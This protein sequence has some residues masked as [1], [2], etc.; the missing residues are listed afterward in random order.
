MLVRKAWSESEDQRLRDAV[1][2][3]GGHDWPA[4]AKHVGTRG[5]KPCRERWCNHL[6]PGVHKGAF[7][8][9]EDALIVKFVDEHGKARRVRARAPGDP[10]A[11]RRL[12]RRF[13]PALTRAPPTRPRPTH[14]CDRRSGRRSHAKSRGAP[15][16]RSR[17]ATASSNAGRSRSRIGARAP[18]F[19]ARPA[20]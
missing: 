20:A 2:A 7:T 10:A 4:I 16:P 6:K 13:T 1:Q 15:R 14:R 17:I 9:H 19:P 12:T 5:P 11:S 18:I 8:K 3:Y